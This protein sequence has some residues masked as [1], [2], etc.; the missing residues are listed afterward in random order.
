MPMKSEAQRKFLWATNPETARKF[1]DETPKG[2]LPK[3]LGKQSKKSTKKKN[4]KGQIDKAF[5]EKAKKDPDTMEK[6]KSVKKR[7]NKV[8]QESAIHTFL[9]SLQEE[10]KPKSR[11]RHA[12]EIAGAAAIGAAAPTAIGKTAHIPLNYARD[13]KLES[14]KAKVRKES[15]TKLE[16]QNKVKKALTKRKLRKLMKTNPTAMKSLTVL[17]AAA[18]AGAVIRHKLKRRKERRSEMDYE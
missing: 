2:K 11:K 13:M 8:Q 14:K 17:G 9:R 5:E 3:K 4:L 10:Y 1:E 7:L 15:Y 6:L 12:A 16:K 18:G